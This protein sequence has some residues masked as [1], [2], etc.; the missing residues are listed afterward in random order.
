MSK[1]RRKRTRVP[2]GFDINII[3]QREHINAKTL[4]ISLTGICCTSDR[5]LRAA[6]PCEI[7]LPL[8]EET[9]L[10]MEGKILRSDEK[11]AI[12]AFQSMDEDTFYHLKRLMQY[13]AGDPELIDKELPTPAFD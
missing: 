11:E 9:T 6:E 8:N 7:I 5:R 12:I 1:E 3:V 2:V 4:N 13:N 10:V